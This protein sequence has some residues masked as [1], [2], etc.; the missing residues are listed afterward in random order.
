MEA[1]LVGAPGSGGRT[2]GRALADRHGAQFV[3]LTGAPS[4]RFDELSGLRRAEEAAKRGSLSLIEAES[5]SA[6]GE[7]LIDA[8]PVATASLLIESGYIASLGSRLPRSNGH[9][10]G[11]R[12][13]SGWVSTKP[14]VNEATGDQQIPFTNNFPDFSQWSRGQVILPSATGTK[15]DFTE[16]DR[17]FAEQKGWLKRNGEPNASASERYRMSKKLTWHHVEDGTTM[18][19]VPTVIHGNTPHQG[20]ASLLRGPGE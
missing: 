3:D 15:K 16:A 6:V 9:W 7:M 8:L 4:G 18:M 19:L 11:S 20:G 10:T 2:V 17:I 12:G 1:V 13:Q 5:A 14:A